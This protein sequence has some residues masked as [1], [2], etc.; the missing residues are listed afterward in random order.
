MTIKYSWPF[1]STVS[2]TLKR[3]R[4]NSA[5]YI[6]IMKGKHLTKFPIDIFLH[7][8]LPADSHMHSCCEPLS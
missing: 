1:R 2:V 8:Y 4:T 5:K 6:R 3:L 7:S